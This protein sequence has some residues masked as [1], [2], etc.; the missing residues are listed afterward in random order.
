M[1]NSKQQTVILCLILLFFGLVITACGVVQ[2]SDEEIEV[3]WQSSAH[4]DKEAHSFTRWNDAEPAEISTNCA[5]CHSTPGYRDF[6]GVEPGTT[7]GQV[8]HPVP[9]GTTIECEACHN[10]AAAAKDSVLMPSGITI[11]GLDKSANCMEC[12]QGRASANSV[13]EAVA[14]QTPDVVN[15]ELRLPNIHN[16]PAGPTQYGAEAKGGFE[17]DGRSYVGQYK[18]VVEFETCI[19]CHDPHTLQVQ[20]EKCSACHLG[21]KTAEDLANIRTNNIDYDGDGNINEGM[22]G[23]IETLQ[24]RLLLAMNV[25]A[26]KTEGVER[27]VFDGRFKN[28]AGD[29]YTTWT[30]RL[31]QAAYNYQYNAKDHGNYAHNN[32]YII[33]LLYD[34][35]NDLGASNDGLIRPEN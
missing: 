30:P 6:L 2:A 34:S 21:V 28:E 31:L 25:Y 5:K 29:N 11:S 22:G 8:D 26:A 3:R 17:Y 23:E 1:L 35:L 20:V 10:E 13:T 27:I 18:H 16:N 4:A 32:K 12:H 7:A 9:V 24:K 19:V 33:Q 14:G 15:T